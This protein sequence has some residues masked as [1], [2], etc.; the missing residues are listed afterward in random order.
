MKI[1]EKKQFYKD[2]VVAYKCD[3][4]GI[5]FLNNNLIE[6]SAHHCEWGDDSC[7]SYEYADI[8]S[9]ECY[10]KQLELFLDDFD[11]YNSA[12]IDGKPIEFIDN[13]ISLI[14]EQK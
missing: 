12:E 1:T 10:I 8:C 5:E 7:E 14:K 13:L 11:G 6:V 4:C 2:V 3:I 9:P